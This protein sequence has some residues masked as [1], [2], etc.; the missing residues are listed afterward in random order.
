MGKP[1]LSFVTTFKSFDIEPTGAQQ[2]SAAYS[3]VLNK[4]PDVVVVGDD[5]GS[6]ELCK[7]Y[8][9]KYL[10][11]VLRG[12]SVGINCPAPL[13]PSLLTQGCAK[14]LGEFVC[15]IN[16][17]LIISPKFYRYMCK[18][19]AKFGKN[20]FVTGVRLDYKWY[21]P[22]LD[23][24]AYR[25]MWKLSRKIGK[26][27]RGGGTDFFIAHKTWWMSQLKTMKPWLMGLLAWDNW[28][29]HAAVHTATPCIDASSVV[30]TM[31]P[32]HHYQHVMRA[33][34]LPPKT[35]LRASAGANHNKKLVKITG[36][37]SIGHNAF[38]RLRNDKSRFWEK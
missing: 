26:Y 31:H 23:K 33:A 17:D 38:V 36:K 24:P 34:K 6:A 19:L 16:S 18:I 22:V 15:L 9:F 27:H 20:C 37:T 28:L 8:K 13:L 32:N 29:Q 35:R 2:S 25:K 11:T 10:P 12:N 1:L 3:W 14:A 21:G 4:V 5:L 7:E 30:D